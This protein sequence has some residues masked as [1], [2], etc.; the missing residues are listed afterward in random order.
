MSMRQSPYQEVASFF[1][2]TDRIGSFQS[3]QSNASPISDHEA[4]NTAKIHNG[5]TYRSEKIIQ[6]KIHDGIH[7]SA[8]S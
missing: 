8:S 6:P 3:T 4:K 5:A 7:P 1:F 2:M